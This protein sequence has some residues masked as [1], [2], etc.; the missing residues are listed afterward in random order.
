MIPTF[1]P[2]D[3]SLIDVILPDPSGYPVERE[4]ADTPDVLKEA[5]GEAAREFPKDLWIEPKDWADRARDNDKYHTWG[6]NYLDRYTNQTPTHECT[7]HSLRANLEA[8]RN[9]QRGIIYADGPKANF[10]YEESAKGSVWLSP[11]SVYSEAN[12][13]QWG[14]ANVRQVL[15]IAC[16]RGMLPEKIQPKEYGFKHALQ[17]TTGKGGKNQSSGPWVRLSGFPEGWQET[18]KHFKPIEVIFPESWEQA[19]CLVLH[20]MLV[21]VGRNGHAI[22]WAHAAFS[23]DDL[24]GLDYPDSYDLTRRDSLSTVKRAWSGAFAVAT[25]ACPDDWNNPAG[26]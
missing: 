10:R 3:P 17:G 8:A 15:E 23:G 2:I 16:R 20:G 21:S 12:P 26:I 6:M 5:C 14:G 9:R 4:A 7:T 25:V 24:S 18:A 11:L 22:P 13:G 19:V 1:S